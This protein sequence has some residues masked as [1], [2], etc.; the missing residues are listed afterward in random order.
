MGPY[1]GSLK[2][3]DTLKLIDEQGAELLTIPYSSEHPWPV[4]ARRHR[5]LARPGQ[6]DLRRGRSARVGHQRCRL[7]L[8]G[9]LDPYRPSPLRNVVINEFMAHTDLPDVDFIE[10]YNHANQA[11]NIGGCILTDDASTNRFVI[12]GGTTIPARGFVFY[13]DMQLGFALECRRRN[14]LLEEPGRL[15]RPRCRGIWRPGER[16]LLGTL[17]RRRGGVLPARLKDRSAPT[18]APSGSATSSSMN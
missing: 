5:P 9:A 6:P 12:P 10:L 8:A 17:A 2:N 7:G 13:T 15:A 11:V 18:T 14:H 3:P 1:T 16:R 4:A